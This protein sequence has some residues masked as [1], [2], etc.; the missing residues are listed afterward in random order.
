MVTKRG[1]PVVAILIIDTDGNYY[2]TPFTV[3]ASPWQFATCR[4]P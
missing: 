3:S 2:I 4:R 1:R